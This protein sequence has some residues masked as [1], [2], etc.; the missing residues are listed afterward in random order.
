MKVDPVTHKPWVTPGRVFTAFKYT[1][2]FLLTFNVWFWYREDAAAAAHLFPGGVD[3]HNLNQAYSATVDTVPWL[4]LLYL[5]ELETSVIHDDKLRGGLK[6]VLMLVR[7]V[8]YLFIISAFWGYVGNWFQITN[9]APFAAADPCALLDSGLSW[10]QDYDD[11]PPLDAT[12]CLGLAGHE[13]VQ[14]AGTDIIGTTEAARAAG[15]L[16]LT[17]VINSLAWLL[18]VFILEVEVLLQLWNKLGQRLV[19]VFQVSKVVV[20]G[21]L[22]GAAVYWWMAG[23]FL[24]FWDAFLWLIAFVFIEMN[25]FKWQAEVQEEEAHGHGVDDL[26]ALDGS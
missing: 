8:C 5:F 6:W 9:L 25:I 2:F 20:Y 4:I 23:D 24:D 21:T 17:D 16:A 1:V 22:F 7:T 13:L 18:V 10:I 11:Y 26:A 19:R 14:V 3:W 12:A 15:L